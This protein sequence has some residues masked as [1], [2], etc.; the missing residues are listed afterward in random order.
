MDVGAAFSARSRSFS[1][2]YSESMLVSVYAA[3]VPVGL[4]EYTA[5][6]VAAISARSRSAAASSATSRDLVAVDAA[7]VM[8]G[9]RHMLWY[10]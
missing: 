10:T 9:C 4:K 3:I 2:A 1:A 7:E 6:T 5:T 8:P